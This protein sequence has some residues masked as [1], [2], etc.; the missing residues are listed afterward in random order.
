MDHEID[1]TSARDYLDYAFNQLSDGFAIFD[2]DDRL[3]A[4]NENY[5][6]QYGDH[7]DIVV[8]GASFGELV[9]ASVDLGLAVHPGMEPDEFVEQCL[10]DF[11]ARN[12]SEFQTIDGRMI[13]AREHPLG[14]GGVACIRI[15]ITER[16]EIEDTLRESEANLA[17]AQDLANSGSW[18]VKF[19]GEQQTTARWSA[20]LCRIFGIEQGAVPQGFDA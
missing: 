20:Q 1:D 5:R 17:E 8:P 7:R 16:K 12:D 18:A 3:I 6:A 9:Q 4:C 13:E 11:K 14:D 19:E 15:D 10:A 2:A